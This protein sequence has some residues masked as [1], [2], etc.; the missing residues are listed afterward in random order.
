MEVSKPVELTEFELEQVAGGRI[1]ID[2]G[3]RVRQRNDSINLTSTGNNNNG[4]SGNQV[5]VGG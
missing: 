4:V 2:I 3:N 5:I 1:D